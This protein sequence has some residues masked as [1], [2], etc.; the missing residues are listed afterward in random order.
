MTKAYKDFKE[1]KS[2]KYLDFITTCREQSKEL[3][4]RTTKFVS[5]PSY[6]PATSLQNS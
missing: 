4:L 3:F 5:N 2:N 1:N 6:R